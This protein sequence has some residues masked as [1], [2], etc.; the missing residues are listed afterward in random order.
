MNES[1][2]LICEKVCICDPKLSVKLLKWIPFLVKLQSD[3]RQIYQKGPHLVRFL[4]YCLK[5][6]FIKNIKVKA[7]GINPQ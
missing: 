4:K 2:C 3:S 1:S 6:D 5:K 7:T